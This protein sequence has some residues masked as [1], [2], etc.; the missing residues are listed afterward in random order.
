MKPSFA[1]LSKARD[2][3]KAA[4]LGT[5][6]PATATSL[7]PLKSLDE[8]DMADDDFSTRLDQESHPLV[9]APPP[10]F[11]RAASAVRPIICRDVTVKMRYLEELRLGRVR[12]ALSSVTPASRGGPRR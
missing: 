1:W 10:G 5:E 6:E 8:F 3:A 12:P 4:T 2:N 9:Q 7:E 11:S